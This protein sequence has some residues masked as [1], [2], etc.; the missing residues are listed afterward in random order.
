MS[1]QS[2][3]ARTTGLKRTTRTAGFIQVDGQWSLDTEKLAKELD[4]LDVY[5]LT[6]QDDYNFE[7]MERLGVTVPA[8][9]KESD[10]AVELAVDSLGANQDSVL[11]SVYDVLKMVRDGEIEIDQDTEFMVLRGSKWVGVTKAEL[12][13]AVNALTAS[14]GEVI[15]DAAKAGTDAFDKV[16][17]DLAW[18]IDDALVKV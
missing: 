7:Y 17:S 1:V 2:R 11:G 3:L 16:Y 13:E 12:E 5:W 8:L 4:G 6:L 14:L 18:L 10:D 15:V 9:L